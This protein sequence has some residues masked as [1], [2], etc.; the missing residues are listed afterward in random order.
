MAALLREHR[1]LCRRFAELEQELRAVTAE[2]EAL[3]R[4]IDIRI[5]A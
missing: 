2:L 5:D 1:R 3:D 4:A